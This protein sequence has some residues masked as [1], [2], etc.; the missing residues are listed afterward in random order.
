MP[1]GISGLIFIMETIATQ[2]PVLPNAP[3]LRPAVEQRGIEEYLAASART[4]EAARLNVDIAERL[5]DHGMDDEELAIGLALHERAKNA[6][7]AHHETVFAGVAALAGEDL[8]EAV[9]SARETFTTFRGV[10]R[11]VFTGLTERLHLR[12]VG[13]PPDDLQRFINSAHAAYMAASSDPYAEKLTKRGY[14][15]EKLGAY[16]EEL[17]ALA[18]WGED[19]PE[20]LGGDDAGE[21]SPARRDETYNEFKEFMKEFKGVAAAV[22]RKEPEQLQKLGLR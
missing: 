14:P 20:M 13:E 6:L 10:A 1:G 12:L 19:H 7:A 17:D 21:G 11:A 3:K 16:C 5:Y 18:R 2:E 8:K 15:P 9:A 4:L 22:F